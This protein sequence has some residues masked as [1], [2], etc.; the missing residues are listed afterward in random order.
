VFYH[1][2]SVPLYGEIHGMETKEM[3][4]M[5]TDFNSRELIF[6]ILSIHTYEH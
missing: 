6:L 5:G 4:W 1:T 3:I 2:I